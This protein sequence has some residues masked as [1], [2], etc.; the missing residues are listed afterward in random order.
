MII[1]APKSHHIPALRAFWQ[2]AFGDTDAFL[3]SFFALAYSADRCR[4]V[5]DGDTIAAVVYW[6][7]C[8]WEEKRLAYLYAVATDKGYRKRGLCRRL[9]EDTHAHLYLA[10]YDGCILV[11][12][13][14]ALFGMYEK[15][16]YTTCSYIR[17]FEC[18]A[19]KPIPLRKLTSTEYA[20]LRRQYLPLGGV[21][22]EQEVLAL[23]QA[24]AAFCAGENCLFVYTL[25]G[26]ELTVHELLGDE[27]IAEN[28]VAAL[29]CT[30]G[31]FR[32]PG[33]EKPFAMYHPLT[34]GQSAPA[35]F[36]LAMD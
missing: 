30:E 9:M 18:A 31:N 1:D 19:D 36:G 7:D 2:Q 3:D 25:E 26:R 8:S 6:F 23:L 22:Q 28:I 11:P 15:M 35:Y 10:G 16:G 17:E 5:M 13:S 32:A 20:V 21:V 4:C 12:G 34:D 24:Q 29:G 14:V 27:T 33:N